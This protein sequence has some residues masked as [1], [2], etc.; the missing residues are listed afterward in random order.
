VGDHLIQ[1][2][3]DARLDF[4]MKVDVVPTRLQNM[5]GAGGGGTM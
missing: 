1:Y 5:D 2:E 3:S 4:L